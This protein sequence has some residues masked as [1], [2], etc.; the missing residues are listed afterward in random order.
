MQLMQVSEILDTLL[1]MD[2]RMGAASWRQGWMG[3]GS[4][5]IFES[6]HDYTVYC[7]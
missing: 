6:F 1:L 7:L 2:I 5:G 3:A 4:L